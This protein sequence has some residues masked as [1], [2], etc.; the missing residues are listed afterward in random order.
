[1]NQNVYILSIYVEVMCVLF[2]K[3]SFFNIDYISKAFLL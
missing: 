3:L 1:M 2:E